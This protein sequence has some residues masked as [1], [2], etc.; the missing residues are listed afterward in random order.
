MST[1]QSTTGHT[2]T[3]SITNGRHQLISDEP[4]SI[5]GADQ[6]FSPGELLRASLA[7]CSGITMRMYASR[8]GWDVGD[9][10]VFVDKFID[11]DGEQEYYR[12]R[13]QIGG[14]LD[15]KQ[16]KRMKAIADKC[17]VHKLLVNSIEIRSILE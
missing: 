3:T 16:R 7:S 9:I 14:E 5:G 15:E 1:V 6:G 8:K 17:P 11:A 13:I 2:F 12:K 4:E 10:N